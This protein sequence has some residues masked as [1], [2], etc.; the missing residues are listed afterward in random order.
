M[1]YCR[2][3][4]MN[5]MC[6]VYVYAD[7]NGGWSTHIAGR[8]KMFPPIPELPL[9]LFNFKGRWSK[10][11]RKVI[12]PDRKTEIIAHA[13]FWIWSKWHRWV[14]QFS[15][16]LIPFK[17]LNLP[18]DGEYFTDNTAGECADRLERLRDI[19]YIVPQYAI[20]SLRGEAK[21]TNEPT[22]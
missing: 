12:Y 22:N 5:W 8:R 14:H 16:S 6:D 11:K 17:S 3:S 2:F 21:E 4:S 7:V 15:Y 1:S 19:G 9:S 20:D 10:K 13:W 18:H